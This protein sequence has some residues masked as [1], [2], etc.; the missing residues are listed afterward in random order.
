MSKNIDFATSLT[1]LEK[2]VTELDSDVPIEKA[3]VLF[4]RGMQLSNECEKFL[5]AAEQ[6]VEILKRTTSGLAVEV[7]TMENE[8]TDNLLE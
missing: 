6:K 5:T 3:L 1:E 8:N 7:F 4:E 2:V